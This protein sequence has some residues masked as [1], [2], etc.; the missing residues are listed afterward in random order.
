MASP[1]GILR[2]LGT[3][4]IV[5]GGLFFLMLALGSQIQLVEA[6]QLMSAGAQAQGIITQK[7]A[8]GRRSSRHDF[9]YT[10]SVGDGRFE[11]T[12]TGIAYR[13]YEQMQVGEKIP[14]RYEPA[15]PGKN[16]TSPELA[17]LEGWPNRLFGPVLGLALLGWGIARIVRRP[18]IAPEP[19]T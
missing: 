16:V 4:L 11:K 13:D 7:F 10:F 9:T 5:G 12:V 17:D 14:V 1:A 2:W 15:N 3:T 19:G 18:R 8:G 6:R